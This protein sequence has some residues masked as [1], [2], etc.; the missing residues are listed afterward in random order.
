MASSKITCSAPKSLKLTAPEQAE[1]KK[2]FDAAAVRVLTKYGRSPG[3]DITN[4]DGPARSATRKAG[5]K[6]SKKKAASKK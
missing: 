2:A 4:W 5:K 3:S 6:G 1:L